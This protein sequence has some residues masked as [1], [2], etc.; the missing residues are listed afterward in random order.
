MLKTL[1]ETSSA[2]EFVQILDE[3]TKIGGNVDFVY[4]HGHTTQETDILVN[5]F[6]LFSVIV[7]TPS[8]AI[9][10]KA[11]VYCGGDVETADG[12]R[13]G[14]ET[15]TSEFTTVIE[16]ISDAGFKMLPGSISFA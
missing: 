11:Q 14:S 8:N 6:A 5:V 2:E 13:E 4:C 12:K 9:L 10:L 3:L 15:L 1:I 7:Q 16:Y